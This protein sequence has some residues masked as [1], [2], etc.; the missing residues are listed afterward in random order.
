MPP[1][2]AVTTSE[3]GAVSAPTADDS[4]DV[5]Q[6]ESLWQERMNDNFSS[7]FAVGPGDV[8]QVAVPDMEELKSREVRVSGDKTIALPV[9]GMIHVGNMTE[10]QVRDAISQRLAKYMK[11]PQVDVFVKEYQ[12]R[13]VAVEGMVQ[14]PGLYSLTSRSDTIMDM[15]SRAGGMPENA[16][17]RVIFIPADSRGGATRPAGESLAR[18]FQAFQAN[19]DPS[20]MK[21]QREMDDHGPEM[22]DHVGPVA[23]GGSSVGEHGDQLVMHAF[24]QGNP[25]V[26]NLAAVGH[27]SHLDVPV[28]PGDVIIVPAAGQVMVKGWVQNPG[29]YRIV[30]GM[31]V[32][33][34]VT[35]AG[36]EMFSSSA[37]LLRSADSGQKIEMPVDLS[38]VQ[39]GQQPDIMVQSGD[40]V[41]VEKSVLGAVPYAVY[42]VFNKFSTGIPIMW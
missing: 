11:D 1:K 23:A 21:S 31:T 9:L 32:L 19:G 34:A 4:K 20:L 29:A 6:L 30:P 18:N 14:K 38:K 3:L 7:D 40:V 25:I 17:T 22:A 41:L 2:E 27:E 13:M 15:I 36:G 39:S 33:G 35:A 8:I 37:Q 12:S 26:I 16:S 5:Q 28:R 42:E 10:Q 24:K